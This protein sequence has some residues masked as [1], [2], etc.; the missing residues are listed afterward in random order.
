MKEFEVEKE[1]RADFMKKMACG[2][3][4]VDHIGPN[5]FHGWD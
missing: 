1:S 5:R 3:K 4:K 2:G